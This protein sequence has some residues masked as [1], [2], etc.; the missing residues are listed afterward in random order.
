[1]VALFVCT[2]FP[3]F[4]ADFNLINLQKIIGSQHTGTCFCPWED[5]LI[6]GVLMD[7]NKC[8]CHSSSQE[9]VHCISRGGFMWKRGRGL[10]DV[11]IKDHELY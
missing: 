3:L 7:I 8:L 4:K 2:K 5:P 10:Q 1:M 9:A 6:V 11:Q